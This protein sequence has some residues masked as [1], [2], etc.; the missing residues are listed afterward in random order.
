MKYKIAQIGTFDLENYGDL[1]FPI[2][3]EK[4]IK[5]YLNVEEILLFSPEGGKMPFYPDKKVYSLNELEEKIKT[6]NINAIV[7]GGGDLIRYDKNV[8]PNYGNDYYTTYCLWQLPIIL[9][10]KYD[11]PVI[12]N[13]PGVPFN[14]TQTYKEMSELLLNSC[15]YLSVRD[16]TSKQRLKLLDL[17]Q[18]INVIPDTILS[19]S[20]VY[21]HKFL[22]EY[23][24]KLKK[25]LGIDYNYIIFQHNSAN[26]TNNSYIK[27]LQSELKKIIEHS[28]IHIIFMPIG[29]VHNDKEKMEKIY[30]KDN[31]RM[32]FINRKLSPIEMLSL[33]SNSNFFIGTSLHGIITSNSY[34]IP[35][36]AINPRHLTKIDGYFSQIKCKG[37]DIDDITL[38]S[39]KYLSVVNK[40]M[41]FNIN[42][43]KTKINHHFENMAYNI[44]NYKS[45]RKVKYYEDFI[46]LIYDKFNNSETNMINVINIYKDTG[47]GYNQYE[48]TEIIEKAPL[49]I[50]IKINKGDKNIRIDPIELR[51]IVINKI[52]VFDSNNNKIS[53]DLS[54]HI[55][56]DGK[57]YMITT[58]PQILIKNNNYTKIKLILDY[59]I[60]KNL[61]ILKN[62]KD[63]NDKLKERIEKIENKTV[64]KIYAKLKKISNYIVK[65]KD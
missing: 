54:E 15:D 51:Y 39:K 26:I 40:K 45:N 60:I 43:S 5:Q 24:K 44:S 4:K 7:I 19:I 28:D 21:N 50:E 37:N 13:N 8:A 30:D 3:F 57:F 42:E 38:I 36:I 11:I 6:D 61:E 22:T 20:D 25:E 53:F 47:N 64:Y 10:K 9:A 48:K 1:L 32:H 16:V 33:I 18:K 46:N 41:K 55:F 31:N 17:N 14:I 23:W 49:S 12:F 29:Y 58:D 2:V 65:R 63:K 34:N 56:Y 35:A 27:K 52:D 59:E 62:I